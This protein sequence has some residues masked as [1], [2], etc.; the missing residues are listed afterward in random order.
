MSINYLITT[1]LYKYSNSPEVEANLRAEIK[2]A[3][4]ELRMR[5]VNAWVSQFAETGYIWEITDDV[6]G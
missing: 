3:Y 1:S 2:A 5:L 6:T 4:N